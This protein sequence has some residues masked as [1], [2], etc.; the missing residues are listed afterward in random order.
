Q[1]SYNA[2]VACADY[3]DFLYIWMN[4][5]RNMGYHLVIDKLV[6]FGEHHISVQGE[7]SSELR[8]IKNINSLKFAFSTVKL[9]VNSYRYFNIWSMFFRKPKIHIKLL[10]KH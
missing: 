3:K 6:L 10:S 1:L 2:A 5:H 7:K 8:R 9:T 4:S